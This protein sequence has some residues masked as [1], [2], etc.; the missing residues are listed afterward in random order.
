[1]IRRIFALFSGVALAAHCK[2]KRQHFHAHFIG[3]TL[4][5]AY[6][7]TLA[8][9]AGR[10]SLSATGHAA[11]VIGRRFDA[12]ARQA[13][14]VCTFLV[15]AS[16]AVRDSLNDEF[17]MIR[18]EV[19]HCGVGPASVG[20]GTAAP[21][22]RPTVL[23]VARVVDKKGYD[24]SIDVAAEMVK[25]ERRFR[26]IAIGTGPS[27][28]RLAQRSAPLE[29]KE[30]WCWLGAQPHREVLRRL[31]EEAAIFVLPCV[32]SSDGDVDGIPVALMEAMA[33]GIPVVTSDVGGIRELVIEGVTGR[34]LRAGDRESFVNAI[35]DLCDHFET[36]H[37]LGLAG[38]FH[39][40]RYFS[41]EVEAKKLARLFESCFAR[42]I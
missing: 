39:V 25:R 14:S 5:V 38:Q 41:Q 4:E 19:V 13:I 17:P 36:R 42:T 20:R 16:E 9:P 15:A 28:H 30:A 29:A 31:D 26:W 23:T 32:E 33:R 1:M 22:S 24:V 2:T 35:E 7:A 8:L 18:N 40:R 37:R 10:A 21:Q 3:R 11:D 34:L 12:G 6:I 27:M